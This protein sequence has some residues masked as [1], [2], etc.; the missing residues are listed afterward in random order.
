[1][2]SLN[3]MRTK[4]GVVLSVI[5]AGALLAFVL[6]LK[7]EM[8][9]S[10]N[11]P[12]VG[13][14]NGEKITYTEYSEAY[15]AVKAQSGDQNY[16]EEQAQRILGGAWQQLMAKHVLNP[17]LEELGLGVTADERAA[18]IMGQKPSAVLANIFTDPKTGA[19]SVAAVSEFLSQVAGN[20]QAQKAWENISQQAVLDRTMNKYASLVKLGTYTNKLQVENA[21]FSDNSVYDGKYV[22][23]KYTSVADSTVNVSASEV[24]AYYEAHKNQYKQLP[25][26]SISYVVF[27]VDATEL[28]KAQIEADAKALAEKMAQAEDL[29]AFSRDNRHVSV[30]TTYVSGDQLSKDELEALSAGK[31]YGPEL[32]NGEW[33]ASRVVDT[34]NVA[35]K[36]T[37][38]HIVLPY[39]DVNLA[40]SLLNVA[41]SGADFAELAQ[42][43][44]V[45]ETAA[46]GGNIGETPYASLSPEFANELKD[47]TVGSVV[48]IVYGTSI[49]IMKVTAASA[50]K[51]HY[52]IAS[53]TCPVEASQ[54]T[55]RKVHTE[56]STFA[57]AAKGSIQNFQNAAD[58]QA[59]NVRNS[60]VE[61]GVRSVRGITDSA[62]EL[63]RWA[64]DNKVGEVSDIINLGDGYV[65]AVVTAEDKAE[66]QA[67]AAV[68]A[69]IRATLIQD[70]KAEVLAAK[71]AGATIDEVATAAGAEV[72]SFE[73]IKA[74]SY[75]NPGLGVEPRVVGA[76]SAVETGALS[77]PIKGN[78]GVYVIVVENRGTVEEPTTEQDVKVKIQAQ[79]ADMA[80]NRA[81]YAIQEMAN[82]K[83][84]TVRYF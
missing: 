22:C 33:R 9:F 70:K 54:E 13:E 58:A 4:F 75:Y 66:Y 51:R 68:E 40:D 52:Q 23:A 65:V 1:M 27:D 29:K 53:M 16:S 19:Y 43:Y 41:R 24:K 3:T 14:I 42:K 31:M 38:S 45:A 30:A 73:G 10:N 76:M 60:K 72:E 63:I 8:G 59:L 18:M 25:N 7:T 80:A 28:D 11:D 67:V 15:E 50:A 44:S 62:L 81:F 78:S 69:G 17:G 55:K 82:V 34:R 20:P 2:I 5:I 57:V 36:L 37:L 21:L 39:T 32:V 74:S 6:S 64:N 49:Q 71:L 46:E 12:K 35:E 26:K 56:A 77:K 48:K 79:A 83:D 61:Q 47:A 84:L